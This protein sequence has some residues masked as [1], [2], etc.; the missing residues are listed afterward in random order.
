[1]EDSIFWKWLQNG[2]P[3]NDDDPYEGYSELEIADEEAT[4]EQLDASLRED[5]KRVYVL[6]PAKY[7]DMLRSYAILQRLFPAPKAQ[8]TYQLNEHFRGV[9]SIRIETQLADISDPTALLVVVRAAN[10]F[11][12]YP[13]L[14]GKVRI[15]FTFA[16]IATAVEE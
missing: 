1:M 14:N 7:N 3:E 4:L 13:L 2:E 16:D 15:A 6:N 11:E 5:A 8:I 10:T 12:I 9:G